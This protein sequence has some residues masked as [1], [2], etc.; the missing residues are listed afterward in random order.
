[1]RWWRDD[2]TRYATRG[3]QLVPAAQLLEVHQWAVDLIQQ[4]MDPGLAACL[5]LAGFEYLVEFARVP[6][7]PDVD[8]IDRAL[9][10]GLP[11]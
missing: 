1:M 8:M 9:A 2:A 6:E 3:P 11:R 4:P 5:K 10:L 7:I